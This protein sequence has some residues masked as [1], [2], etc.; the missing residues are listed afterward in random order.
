[1][2]LNRRVR[3]SVRIWLALS[4]PLFLACWFVPENKAGDMA[5][6]DIWRVLVTHDHIFCSTGEML[7]RIGV[8]A[9]VFAVPS[10][11]IGWV[12][13]FPVCAVLDF[14]LRGKVKEKAIAN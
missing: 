10:T 9:L 3:G 4:I 14:L 7:R 8:Y 2:K 6:G 5:A 11:A 12:L 1:M 13:Q